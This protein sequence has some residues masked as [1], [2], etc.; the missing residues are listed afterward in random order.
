MPSL[1]PCASRP[2]RI[3]RDGHG[4]P[5]LREHGS[6][7]VCTGDEELRWL[8]LPDP[9]DSR[10]L[11]HEQVHSQPRIS[12]NLVKFPHFWSKSLF[13]LVI[14]ECHHMKARALGWMHSPSCY[15]VRVGHDSIADDEQFAMRTHIR[16]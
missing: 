13:A 4:S 10:L 1:L 5:V 2:V 11:V 9:L 8:E 12:T 15:V 3:G 14:G 6:L 7:T 16:H